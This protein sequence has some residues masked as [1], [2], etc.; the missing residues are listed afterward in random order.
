MI[1]GAAVAAAEDVDRKIEEGALDWIHLTAAPPGQDS[2][3]VVREFDAGGA[4]LGTGAEG[5]GEN[6]VQAAAMMQAQAPGLVAREIARSA[7][8][9]GPFPEAY[10]DAGE[11]LPA[12]ALVIEGRFTTLNPGSKAKR[13]FA[14]FGAGKGV[15]EIEGRVT[16][17]DGDVLAE[18]RQ[19]RLTVM[20]VFGGD[21]E[22]KMRADCERFGDDVAS[23]LRA[24]AR[25]ESL[26]H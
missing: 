7:K 20:G 15:M 19:K 14:G 22:S 4:D 16:N 8:E 9:D 2:V 25:G 24:W 12:N 23:F 3:V 10:V 21:Y 18:F 17:A 11:R 6:H 26:E 13:Y 5:G 1:V